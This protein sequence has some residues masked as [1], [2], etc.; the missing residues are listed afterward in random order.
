MSKAHLKSLWEL[1][2]MAHLFVCTQVIKHNNFIKTKGKL[3]PIAAKA[4][5]QAGVNCYPLTTM[6]PHAITLRSKSGRPSRVQRKK[7]TWERAT[8]IKAILN[9][10]VSVRYRRAITEELLLLPSTCSYLPTPMGYF[11]TILFVFSLFCS[12]I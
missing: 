9:L 4:V 5:A 12:C 10:T 11:I 1:M 2:V 8:L 6:I 3:W 7:L